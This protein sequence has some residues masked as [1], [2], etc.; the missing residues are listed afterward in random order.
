MPQAS[1]NRIDIS[2]SAT[3][4]ATRAL[5]AGSEVTQHLFIR[6]RSMRWSYMRIACTEERNASR[7][8][9]GSP[10]QPAAAADGQQDGEQLL[11]YSHHVSQYRQ[12][13]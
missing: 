6:A 1:A 7:G 8:H 11:G 12:R 2:T 9:R 5:A 3:P 13:H 4:P 10:A